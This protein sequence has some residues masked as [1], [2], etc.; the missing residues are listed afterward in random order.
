VAVTRGSEIGMFH[1]GSTAVVLLEPG[2]SVG[3]PLGKVRYGESL[4]RAG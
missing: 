3:R 1:L 2:V 4:L